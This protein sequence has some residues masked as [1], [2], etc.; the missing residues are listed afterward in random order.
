M[1]HN[2]GLNTH[3]FSQLQQSHIWHMGSP[4]DLQNDMQTLLV[5]LLKTL[6]MPVIGSPSLASI[7]QCCQNKCLVDLNFG[8]YFDV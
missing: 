8:C 7:Q 1:F 4:Q 3:H 6:G 5:E 2:R